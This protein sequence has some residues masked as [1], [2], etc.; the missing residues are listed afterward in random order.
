MNLG[1]NPYRVKNRSGE[2]SKDPILDEKNH[3]KQSGS[4]YLKRDD[5]NLR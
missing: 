5:R 3:K 2:K 1:V 4:F